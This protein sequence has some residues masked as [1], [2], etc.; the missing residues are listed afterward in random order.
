MIHAEFEKIIPDELLE[1]DKKYVSDDGI[2]FRQ[3][4]RE[5][6]K[7]VIDSC[8][9][10]NQGKIKPTNFRFILKGKIAMI[11]HD[12]KCYGFTWMNS[13]FLRMFK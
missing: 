7:Q 1:R 8:Y 5:E 2:S 10:Y 12:V 4:D 3:K 13:I 9:L 11:D 6:L